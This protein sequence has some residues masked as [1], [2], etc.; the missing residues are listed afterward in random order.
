MN[1]ILIPAALAA[2]ALLSACS[3]GNGFPGDS[4]AAVQPEDQ[5]WTVIDHKTNTEYRVPDQL[6]FANDSSE[7]L[8]TGHEIVLALAMV[9]KNHGSGAIE[10]DGFT[11]T[12]GSQRHNDKL[13]IA[14]AEAV[15]QELSHN[16][17]DLNRIQTRGY[18]EREL[19]VDT[20]NNTP[21]A[22]NRRV[23]VRMQN[24]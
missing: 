8:P 1:R 20:P 6:L 19:A 23:V 2:A 12:V 16:G 13:S 14:R 3:G 9:A 10:V 24:G 15:A 7:L 5:R 18:G 22:K 11:D 21:E 17:V 4:H